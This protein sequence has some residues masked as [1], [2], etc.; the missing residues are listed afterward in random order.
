MKSLLYLF[1]FNF[2]LLTIAVQA[3]L[4]SIIPQGGEVVIPINNEPCLSQDERLAIFQLIDQNRAMLSAQGNL[5]SENVPEGTHPLFSWP[6]AQEAGFNYHSI[7]SVT[8]YVDHNPSFPNQI[9]DWNCGTRS[10]DTNNGYNHQGIDIISWPFWW[11]QMDINQSILVAAAEGQIILKTDGNFDRNC[12]FTSDPWNAVFVEHADGSVSWYGHMKQNSLTNKNVGDMVSEGEFLGVMGSSGSSTIPHIHFEVYDSNNNL[13]D[14]YVGPCNPLNNETWWQNQKPYLN[15]GINA[16][17]THNLPPEFFAC[18]NTE[19]TN[20]ER[21]FN[22]GDNIIMA[23]YLRDLIA[24]QNVNLRVRKPDGTILQQWN[25]VL[26]DS[27]Q[28]GYYYWNITAPNEIGIYQWEATYNNDTAIHTFANGTVLNTEDN[29]TTSTKV[30]PNPT[31][32]ILNVISNTKVVSASILDVLGRKVKNEENNVGINQLDLNGFPKGIY[33]IK[34]NT[35]E[36][37]QKTIKVIKK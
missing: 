9:T 35:I 16:V 6:V 13:I 8:N 22:P 2:T 5:F 10:Y 24:G 36:G 33:F 34:L 7:W 29:F 31:Q 23:I 4:T 26:P 18:P 20:E 14:P 3:Q 37:Y 27:F 21:E 12:A 11:K 32:G 28:I 15:S 17:L 1:T 30:F 25:F 19:I